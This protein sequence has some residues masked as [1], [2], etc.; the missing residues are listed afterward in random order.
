MRNPR[1]TIA[2]A[3]LAII[4]ASAS[5]AQAQSSPPATQ[6]WYDRVTVTGYMQFDAVFPEGESRHGHISNFRLRRGRPTIEAQL[7]PLTR[8]RVVWDVS[9]GAA[10]HSAST[11]FVADTWAQR[12]IP[13]FGFVRAGQMLL[14]FG[15]EIHEDT[16]GVRSPLELSHAGSAIAL[17]EQDIGIMLGSQRR[18]NEVLNW[19]FG[20]YNGQGMRHADA[21]SNKT[22]AG[23]LAA[24]V[25][26]DLRVAVSG[27]FGTFL[28]TS[29]GGT[30]RTFDRHVLG[31]D[32]T[33][34]LSPEVKL[35]GELYNVRF[36]DSVTAPTRQARFTGGYLM[37]E[38]WIADWKSIP[39]VRFNRTYGDLSYSSIDLGWRYQYAPNQRLTVQYDIV[40]GARNDSFGVRW[41]LN[42]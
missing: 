23:R 6:R 27:M 41:Q 29:P 36:V 12:Q 28:D 7:D 21:N 1:T 10:G 26:P 32:V 15:R 30:R 14:P 20:F 24:Q 11:A 39:F 2:A 9:T 17:A 5:A 18:E 34:T 25:N 16:G 22:W 31:V 8:V 4:V 42:L 40:K 13:G 3:A 35:S 19:V 33:A 38:G 37:W